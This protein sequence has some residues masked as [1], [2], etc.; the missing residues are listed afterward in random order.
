MTTGE[1]KLETLLPHTTGDSIDYNSNTY[2]LQNIVVSLHNLLYGSYTPPPTHR[3]FI[4]YQPKPG[5]HRQLRAGD[6]I[7]Q[8]D[9]DCVW[10][11]VQLIA[12]HKD[13]T[14]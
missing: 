11:K 2:N 10:T 8:A 14:Q 5:S 4:M 9:D 13:A 6:I 7:A 12:H 3:D 1:Q